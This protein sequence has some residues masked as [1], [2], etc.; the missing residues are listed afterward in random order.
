MRDY[1]DLITRLIYSADELDTM[2]DRK[3]LTP[4]ELLVRFEEVPEEQP[5]L[6]E[7]LAPLRLGPAGNIAP[8]G[9]LSGVEVPRPSA[10]LLPQ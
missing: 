7:A 8:P 4:E 9:S 3:E 6:L 5:R 10:G 1:Q 2:V